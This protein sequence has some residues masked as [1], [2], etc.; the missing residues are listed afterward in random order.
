LRSDL[1]TITMRIYNCTFVLSRLTRA[2]A[3]VIQR[4]NPFSIALLDMTYAR[5]LPRSFPVS[6]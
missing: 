5:L 3:E 6:R 1:S 2:K 4:S